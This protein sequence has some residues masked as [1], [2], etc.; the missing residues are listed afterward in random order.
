MSYPI[1]RYSVFSTH[2]FFVSVIKRKLNKIFFLGK[3][4]FDNRVYKTPKPGGTVTHMV[5]CET[6]KVIQETNVLNRCISKGQR[7]DS[8]SGLHTS[9][10]QSM[11]IH[12]RSLL[13][14]Q[15]ALVARS[16]LPGVSVHVQI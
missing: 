12:I 5:L 16:T 3:K 2:L 6:T 11:L 1:L 15:I 9:V 4:Q 7:A 10:A 8:R 13:M 14:A